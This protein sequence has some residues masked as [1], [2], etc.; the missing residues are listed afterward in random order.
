[1]TSDATTDAVNMRMCLNG[2]SA[3]PESDYDNNCME[4]NIGPLLDVKLSRYAAT[5]HWESSAGV[6]SWPMLRDAH[7][8]W[9][10]VGSGQI[11]NGESY[12]DSV[13]MTLPV[14]ANS[15]IQACVGIPQGTPVV[16]QPFTVPHKAKII[17]MVG[18][19]NDAPESASVKFIIGTAQGSDITYYPPVVINTKDK[20]EKYE[21]DLSKLAGKQVQ[22][23]L[24]VE[25]SGP[26]QQGSAVWTDPSLIQEQ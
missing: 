5:A 4:H 8:G 16:Q 10:Q 25:S 15:W 23:I 11:N 20:L 13:I 21:V 22:F 18:L 3:F 12:P 1:V 7:D 14:A 2:N 6:L 19:T 9:A 17:T 26:L 24:K